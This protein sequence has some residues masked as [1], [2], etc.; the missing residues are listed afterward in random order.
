MKD[1]R[2]YVTHVLDC[3]DR[4]ER[5]TAEGQASFFRGDLIQD[6]VARNPQTLAES[7]KRV[8]AERKSAHPEVDWR[9]VTGF[10]NILVHEY[11]SIGLAR[12]WEI[13]SLDLPVLKEQMAAISRDLPSSD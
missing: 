9:G 1:D 11:L 12:V 2:L 6:A 5:Y 4:I 10:R 3:I 13:V 7:V 8:S